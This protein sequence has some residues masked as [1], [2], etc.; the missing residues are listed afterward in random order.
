MTT[1][2][3]ELFK[4]TGIPLKEIRK[5]G[6][7]NRGQHT[8]LES[9][10]TG[11]FRGSFHK[12]YQYKVV[13]SESERWEAAIPQVKEGALDLTNPSSYCYRNSEI[14]ASAVGSWI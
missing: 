6:L 13:D 8:P 5:Q 3:F 12:C 10:I 2:E 1:T 9:V 14:P 7:T 4:Q 11:R